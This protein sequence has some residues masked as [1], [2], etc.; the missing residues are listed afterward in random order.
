[1]CVERDTYIIIFIYLDVFVLKTN[2]NI[3]ANKRKVPVYFDFLMHVYNVKLNK[4]F[5]RCK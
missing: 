3:N 4:C 5:Q 1:M 2:S